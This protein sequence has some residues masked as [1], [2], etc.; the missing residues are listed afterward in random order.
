MATSKE[1]TAFINS[2][3][4]LAVAESVGRGADGYVL[5]SVCIAQASLETG[6]GTSSLMTKAN[7][8]FGIKAGSSWTGKVYSASTKEVYDGVEQTTTATFRAYDS[9]A[10]SVKDYYDLICSLS[11]YADA[12]S[13][14]GNEKTARQTITA[15]HEGGYATD[16]DYISKVLTIVSSHSL[17]DWDKL[18]TAD[19]TSYRDGIVEIAIG[20]LGNAEPSGD[21]KYIEYYNEVTDAGFALTVAW[22]AIFVTYCARHAE[23]PTTSIPNFASCHL[24]VEWFKK[25]N[26]WKDRDGYTPQKGDI[27]FFLWEGDS[28]SHHVGIVEKIVDNNVHTIEGNKSDSV[29]RRT[30]SMSDPE[31]LGYGVYADGYGDYDYNGTTGGTVPDYDSETPSNTVI[32]SLPYSSY[33]LVEEDPSY[34]LS[35]AL[36]K[37]LP[38]ED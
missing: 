36:Y 21:D 7:A 19:L 35:T 13:Y 29:A 23:I 33:K 5:P 24:G 32:G 15:I 4:K 16:P 34:T 27:I 25:A 18:V 30:Y 12:V 17:T 8:Y 10:D 37:L 20:E 3:G 31:I 2:L 28:I 14:P 38:L 26:A 22:C 6:W 1:I 11:R 9:K